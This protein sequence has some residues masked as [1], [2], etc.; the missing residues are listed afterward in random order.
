[1]LDPKYRE[2]KKDLE[3]RNIWKNLVESQDIASNL[4]K[5]AKGRPDIFGQITQLE[6]EEK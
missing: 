4:Q 3:E 5:L 1:M 2:I 6:L